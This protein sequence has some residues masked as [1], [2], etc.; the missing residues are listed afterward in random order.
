V[1]G[2]EHIKGK[3]FSSVIKRALQLPGFTQDDVHAAE[4]GRGVAVAA[5]VNT[6]R[7]SVTVGFGHHA[8]LQLAGEILDAIHEERLQHIFLIG[9]F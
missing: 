8:V 1:A 9:W 6:G 7:K 4:Q 2:S 5:G 3:D